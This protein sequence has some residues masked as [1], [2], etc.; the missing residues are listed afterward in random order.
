M[1][2]GEYSIYPDNTLI[3]SLIQWKKW[4]FLGGLVET[5]TIS[6]TFLEDTLK[7]H[8]EFYNV[9]NIHNSDLKYSNIKYMLNGSIKYADIKNILNI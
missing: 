3:G 9:K 6:Q 2:Y 8:V 1:N 4:E 7:H 5:K